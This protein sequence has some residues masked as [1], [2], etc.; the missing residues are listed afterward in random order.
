MTLE[1]LVVENERLRAENAALKKRVAEVQA[2]LAQ[3]KA[4]LSEAERAAK[5]QAAPFSKGE[6]QGNPKPPGRKP[7]QVAAHRAEPPR[8]DRMDEARHSRHL[9][10]PDPDLPK[11]GPEF[12]EV[13][14]GFVAS[15]QRDRARLAEPTAPTIVSRGDVSSRYAGG[16]TSVSNYIIALPCLHSLPHDL[17]GCDLT[18]I[19]PGRK[20]KDFLFR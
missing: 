14:H 13:G 3:L 12:P 19:P 8:V 9:D 4:R 16:V 11:A 18:Q 20:L 6:P 10:E 7:G 5:R 2:M 17:N 15:S 1:E